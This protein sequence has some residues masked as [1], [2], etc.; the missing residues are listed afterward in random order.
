MPKKEL[1]YVRLTPEEVEKMRYK[2]K[3]EKEYIVEDFLTRAVVEH[4]NKSDNG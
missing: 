2:M 1:F 4:L 3:A